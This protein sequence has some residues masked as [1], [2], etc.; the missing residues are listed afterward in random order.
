MNIILDIFHPPGVFIHAVLE[1]VTISVIVSK[2]NPS[3][4]TL[5][6]LLKTIISKVPAE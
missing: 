3:L 2:C 4:G 6:L 5:F 1:T